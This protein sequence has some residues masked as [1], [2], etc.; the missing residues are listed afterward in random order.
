MQN[1]LPNITYL[2]FIFWIFGRRKRFRVTG[3]SMQPLL[4]PGEEI[5]INPFAYK[6]ASP[7]VNDLVVATHPKKADIEIIKRISHITED[8]NL[9]LIGDNPK[10]STDSRNFGAIPLKNII[11]KVT[12][13]FG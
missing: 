12:T 5:L 10:H 13:R 3:I 8:D 11:G 2:E 9:F 1:E 6:K 4:Q 7:Q